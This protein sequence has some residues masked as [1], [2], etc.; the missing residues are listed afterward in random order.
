MEINGTFTENLVE[1]YKRFDI[2]SP[3]L[4][5][6]SYAEAVKYV[7]KWIKGKNVINP[8]TKYHPDTAKKEWIG[9]GQPTCGILGDRAYIGGSR[10][11]RIYSIPRSGS[12]AGAEKVWREEQGSTFPS[13]YSKIDNRQ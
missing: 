13:H 11:A 1:K 9:K 6:P 7:P 10:F 2:Y 8:K 12:G 5:Y 4:L 3:T